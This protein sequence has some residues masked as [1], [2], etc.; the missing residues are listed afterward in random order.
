MRPSWWLT[1]E[2]FAGEEHLDERYVS[3]YDAKAQVDRE[4]IWR[5][6]HRTD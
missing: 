4:R 6:F 3:A 2:A 5:S 1:E